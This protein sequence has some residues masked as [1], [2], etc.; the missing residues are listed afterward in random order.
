MASPRLSLISLTMFVV[1]M[2]GNVHSA[3]AWHPNNGALDE[4]IEI[5]RTITT[6]VGNL[7]I[8]EIF[9]DVYVI[10]CDMPLNFSMMTKKKR[11]AAPN[12]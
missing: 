12:I 6:T 9:P 11:T 1:V 7:T 10:Y 8:E 2:A 4:D 3:S 5:E